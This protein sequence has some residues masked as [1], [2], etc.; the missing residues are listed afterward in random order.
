DEREHCGRSR[1]TRERFQRML[2]ELLSHATVFGRDLPDALRRARRGHTGAY[3]IDFGG[4][5][6]FWE[7]LRVP[8]DE[9][10]WPSG[11]VRI[12]RG[13]WTVDRIHRSG[14][15]GTPRRSHE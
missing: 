5:F 8:G 2:E 11:H 9:Q 3:F 13:E 7:A 10:R 12:P 14:H 1:P 15:P 6:G 4:V